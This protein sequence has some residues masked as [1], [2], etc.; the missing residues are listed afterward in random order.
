MYGGK[1]KRKGKNILLYKRGSRRQN[2][3]YQ[4]KGGCV[5]RTCCCMDE[6]VRA[7]ACTFAEAMK[8]CFDHIKDLVFRYRLRLAMERA[9]EAGS[10]FLEKEHKRRFYEG[11]DRAKRKDN[12]FAAQI[13]LLAARE[14]LWKRAARC[15]YT[16]GICYAGVDMRDAAPE[17]KALFYA[18]RDIEFL[19][20]L[21]CIENLSDEEVVDFD[22]FRAVCCAVCICKY[23]ADVT[24]IAERRCRR[25]RGEKGKDGRK[26]RISG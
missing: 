9:E 1:G 18:A 20:G 13:Y 21:S 8:A 5:L 4:K 10:C 2:C 23:G 3:L 12:D 26:K 16:G 6:R 19:G 15:M 22:V 25:D 11:L 24:V 7:N 17:E 14:T